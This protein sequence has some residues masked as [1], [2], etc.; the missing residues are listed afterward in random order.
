MRKLG[1][2]LGLVCATIALS[3]GCSKEEKKPEGNNKVEQVTETQGEEKV[4]GTFDANL[5]E[6]KFDK[7]GEEVNIA[8][9]DLDND[10]KKDN[11][12]VK[13]TEAKD[14]SSQAEIEIKVNDAT[15]KHKYDECGMAIYSLNVDDNT[16]LLALVD[17]GYGFTAETYFFQYKGGE[18]EY[19]GVIFNDI[20]K[21]NDK[22]TDKEMVKIE[23][24]VVKWTEELAI[25]GVY[26][27]VESKWDGK[28][29]DREYEG[30]LNVKCTQDSFK[31]KKDIK[32]LTECKDDASKVVIK[33]N[34][35]IKVTKVNLVAVASE[36]EA[37][38]EYYLN[39]EAE[40]GTKGWFKVS[41]ITDEFNNIEGI[42]S[43]S[44]SE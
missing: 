18:V 24:G 15:Y 44:V 5:Q 21:I 29:I 16:V 43:V 23:K 17:T 42:A 2:V 7:M 27:I 8:E 12:S 10:G 13:A 6:Y 9:V 19:V 30:E 1:L 32:A 39:L 22:E 3:T 34:Q 40:D 14:D 41:D 37:Y 11:V 33:A 20:R 38:V 31:V 28:Q 26:P 36:Y 4:E 35:N 25:T